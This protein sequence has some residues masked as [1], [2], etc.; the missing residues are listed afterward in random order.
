MNIFAHPQN[1]GFSVALHALRGIAAIIVFLSHILKT[2]RSEAVNAQHYPYFFNGEAAVSF[3]FVLSGL[4]VG[5][6]LAKRPLNSFNALTFYLH[7]A[8]RML[9]LLWVTVTIGGLYVLFIEPHMHIT[10]LPFGDMSLV[11]FLSGYV[12][13]S[14]KPNPPIWS[15]FVEIV[16]SILLPF[17]LLT[18][19]NL[20]M[21]ALCFAALFALSLCNLG[22]QHHFNFYLINFYCGLS[23]LW[24]GPRFATLIG[25]FNIYAF[26]SLIFGLFLAF[27]LPRA[28]FKVE[29]GNPYANLIEYIAITPIVALIFYMPQRFRGLVSAPL[30]F[31]GDVSFSL[32]LTHNICIIIMI[33]VF[34]HVS[35]QLFSQPPLLILALTLTLLPLCL[36]I[37]HYS[38]KF[39]ELKGI[40]AGKYIE[41]RYQGIILA[42][43][44]HWLPLV[45]NR[46]KL[47]YIKIRT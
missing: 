30:K 37:A 29:F 28:L 33:N 45:P 19:R 35:P 11:Q 38:Y 25:R 9:P 2:V 47:A 42:C 46:L 24:W 6:S 8:F 16:A 40:A 22:L 14:L 27:Y 17:F 34:W 1:A 23:I 3:F 18:G 7:R 26:W 5:L 4:V 31:L 41:K 12:G 10:Y 13:Y 44:Q 15:I 36:V 39:I 21:V 43:T 32:Y 20:W